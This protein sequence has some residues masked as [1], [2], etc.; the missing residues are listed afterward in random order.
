M[1]PLQLLSAYIKNSAA[2]VGPTKALLGSAPVDAWG[3]FFLL[4]GG[5]NGSSQCSLTHQESA[6]RVF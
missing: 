5:N 6:K 4:K 1:S 2:G 3:Y